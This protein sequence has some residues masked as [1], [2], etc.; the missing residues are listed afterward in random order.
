M[1]WAHSFDGD[2]CEG[3]RPFDVL[4]QSGTRYQLF[5]TTRGFHFHPPP[6]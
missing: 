3:S 5:W 2:D 6:V 1:L 4:L